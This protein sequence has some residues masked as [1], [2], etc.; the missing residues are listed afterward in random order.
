MIAIVNA[1]KIAVTA[2]LEVE[3]SKAYSNITLNKLLSDGSTQNNDRALATAIFY[4]VLDRKITIDYILSKFLTKPVKKLPPYT[5]CVLRAALYQIMYMERIPDSAAVNEAVKLIKSS[6]EKFNAALVNGV[7]RNILRVGYS[8]PDGDDLKSLSIRFSCPEY[9][10]K[11]FIEDY[12]IETTEKM[13][14]EALDTPPV[15]LQV[16]PIKTT[17]EELTKILKKEGTRSVIGADKT[18]VIVTEGIAVKESTAYK[19]GLFYIQDSASKRSIEKLNLKENE[20]VLDMC[21]APGGKSFTAASIMKNSGEILAFDIY[22]KRV[23]LITE[24]AKRLGFTCIK[25][26]VGDAMIFNEN[27]GAFDAVICDVPCSGLGVLRRKPEIK[28]KDN[29]DFTSLPEIQLKILENAARYVGERGRILYSTCTVRRAENEKVTKAFLDKNDE[30]V[31]KYEHT[32]FPHIDFTDGF[33]CA[34]LE[35]K[36]D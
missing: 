19:N 1:R 28:Y 12:G 18:S 9:I 10:I 36:G 3:R 4:G 5:V 8:I 16:N 6:K 23:D 34:L 27:L 30:F 35:K 11:G 25:A 14:E 33:Y 15:I 2:L 20:R 22:E 29:E 21:A 26:A 32:F 13:L 31:L 17:A 24:S 7:L